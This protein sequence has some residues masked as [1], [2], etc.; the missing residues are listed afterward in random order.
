ML[1]ANPEKK[2]PVFLKYVLSY[3]DQDGE[4]QTDMG[5]IKE[6]PIIV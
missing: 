2:N 4:S 5:E 1:I 6:L 3:V